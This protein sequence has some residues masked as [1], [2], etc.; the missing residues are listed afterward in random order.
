MQRQPSLVGLVILFAVVSASCTGSVD[1]SFGGQT[2]AEAAVDLIEG[3]AMRQR[4]GVDPIT[5]AVCHDPISED[6]GATF[7]C[8][9]ASAGQT[10]FFEVIIEEDDRIFAGAT[11]V[12]SEAGVGVLETVAVQEL[13]NQ[14]DFTLPA[15]AME[16]SDGAVIL[17]A[18]Q[19]MTCL[20]TDADTG[21]V[22]E[23]L[24]TVTDIA[25]GRFNVEIVG[26]AS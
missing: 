6:V 15:D 26:E 24:V 17:D 25:T 3:D 8:T 4:L 13:N 14:N 12:V 20:L 5:D 21:L 9:A 10:I 23:A 19:Q 1:I 22:F 2:P 18:D 16:C 11:N 7:E